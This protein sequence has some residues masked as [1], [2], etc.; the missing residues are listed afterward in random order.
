MSL[1]IWARIA[2]AVWDG[3]LGHAAKV[4]TWRPTPSRMQKR[5][6]KPSQVVCV[7]TKDCSDVE[8]LQRVLVAL[9]ELGIREVL[10]YK[11]D[12]VTLP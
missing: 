3:R 9:R 12:A 4:A 10:K 5:G 11:A 2:R 8:D 1:N 6:E 7:Y